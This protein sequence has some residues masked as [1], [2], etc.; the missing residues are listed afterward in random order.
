[1]TTVDTASYISPFIKTVINNQ[2][3]NL[4]LLDIENAF[5][6]VVNVWVAHSLHH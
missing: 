2:F 4:R 1:M 5:I 3:A 6:F